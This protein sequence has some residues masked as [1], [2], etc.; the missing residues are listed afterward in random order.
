MPASALAFALGAAC[1]HALWN[2]LIARARDAEAATAV[3]VVLAVVAFAPVAALTWDVDRAALPFILAGGALHL[4]YF[5]LLAAAYRRAELGLVY[6]LSR[7]LA[8]VIVLGVTAVALAD[9][10]TAGQAA[11]V[12]L[13]AVG[14]VLVRGVGR[15]ADARGTA[16]ALVIAAC[17]AAYTLVDN[18]G[19]RHADPLPYLELLLVGP[20]L[21]Y[22][23]ALAASR[24]AGALRAELG[25]ATAVSALAM[26]GSYTLV[27]A[28]LRLAPAAPVAAVR[29]TSVV[30]AAVLAVV[31]LREPLSWA[32]LAGAGTVAG[33]IVVLALG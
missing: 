25:P 6:P 4:T 15:H 10:P 2:V 28:A 11:G 18:E 20:A 19:I 17:I 9:D 12:V 30:I 33:G 7:G 22:A 16:F 13:V 32:R 3:A 21:I 29:E 23:S 1:L 5:A 8:P 24:G 14:V 27:L 31:V 26:F